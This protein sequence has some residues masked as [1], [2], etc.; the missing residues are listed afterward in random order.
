MITLTGFRVRL[1]H[2]QDVSCQEWYGFKFWLYSC[3]LGYKSELVQGVFYMANYEIKIK[4]GTTAGQ[5]ASR[6]A[7][8]SSWR[9]A[10]CQGTGLNP[11]GKSISERCPACHGHKFWEAE[12]NSNVLTNCGRCAGSGKQNYMGSWAPCTACKGSGKI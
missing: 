3:N 7:N 8:Y 5:P 10:F 4:A 2:N 6:P 11:Y 1:I 9:C 12:V